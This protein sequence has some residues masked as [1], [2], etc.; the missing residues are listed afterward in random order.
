MVS[1]LAHLLEKKKSHYKTVMLGC[2]VVGL[3]WRLTEHTKG[4]KR[5]CERVGRS[6]ISERIESGRRK[7]AGQGLPVVCVE[8]MP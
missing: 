6:C 8:E 5:Q 1:F 3:W 7:F 2:C 4:K